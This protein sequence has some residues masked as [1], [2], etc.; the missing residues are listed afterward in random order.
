MS[1]ADAERILEVLK[2]EEKDVQKKL[3]AKVQT[4]AKTEKDW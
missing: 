2:S 1:R 3:R 4:R